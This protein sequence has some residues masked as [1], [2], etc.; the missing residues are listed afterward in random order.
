[1]W[2]GA[3]GGVI[4]NVLVVLIGA[5]YVALR[6]GRSNLG[7]LLL[8]GGVVALVSGSI[9]GLAIGFVIWK[10]TCKYGKQPSSLPR[11]GIGF[12]C[13]LAYSLVTGLTT[14]SPEPLIWTLGYAVLV[15][16]LAGLMARNSSGATV[17]SSSHA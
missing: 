6:F 8:S 13:F 15:G 14:S 11:L 1:M 10:T 9:A 3:L 7:D 2:R 12:A 17:V 16:G 5:V 4:G